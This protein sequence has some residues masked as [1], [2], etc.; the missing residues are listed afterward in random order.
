MTNLS[1]YICREI[2][3]SITDIPLNNY[4]ERRLFWEKVTNEVPRDALEQALQQ[5]PVKMRDVLI[6]HHATGQRFKEICM[7]MSLSDST[8]R[9]YY[10]RGIFL[11]A[12]QLLT[13]L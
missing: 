3:K 5:L 13:Y 7:V 9:S 10:Q 4:V 8:V 12:R 11:L 2:M 1:L 6:A